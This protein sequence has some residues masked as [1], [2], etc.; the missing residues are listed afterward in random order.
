MEGTVFHSRLWMGK[1][2]HI[3]SPE[4]NLK[5]LEVAIEFYNIEEEELTQLFGTMPLNC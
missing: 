2:G 5:K 4:V 1:E 3:I